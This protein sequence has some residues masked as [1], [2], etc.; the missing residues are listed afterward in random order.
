MST[1][2]SLCCNTNVEIIDYM[3]QQC[4]DMRMFEG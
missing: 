2:C 3:C 4:A 1:M